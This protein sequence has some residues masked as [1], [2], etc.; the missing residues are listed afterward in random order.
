MYLDWIE[1]R[2]FY[3]KKI[4]RMILLISFVVLLSTFDNKIVQA[5][6]AGKEVRGVWVATVENLDWP[7]KPGLSI[8]NQKNEMINNLD[9]IKNMNLNTVYFQ[10]RSYGDAMYNSKL[11]PWSKFLTGTLGKNPGYDPLKFAVEEAHKRNLEF[12]AWFNPFRIGKG[13]NFNLSEY[14]ANLPDNDSLKNNPQW[15]V[16]YKGYYCINPGIPE[17]RA[18]VVNVIMEV[19]KNYNI[20]GVHLDDYFYPYGMNE[21]EVVFD[22][23]SQYQKYGDGLA[24]DD[25][26]RNNVNEFIRTLN[27]NIK[28]K[29]PY[30]KFGVSPFGI[31][32]NGVNNGGSETA[33]LSSYDR[34][35]VDTL[36]WVNQG[37]VDYIV[38]QIYWNIGFNVAPYEKLVKWW[39]D[40]VKNKNV[41]L[42]IGQAAYRIENWNNPNE[43]IN[44]INLNRSYSNVNGSAFFRLGSLKENKLGSSDLIKNSVFMTPSQS[45]SNKLSVSY[46]SHIQNIGWLGDRLNSN[47]SGTTGKSLRL[48]ALKINLQNQPS[49]LKIKYRA[50]IEKNGWQNWVSGGKVAGTVGKSLKL[51]AFQVQLEGNTANKYTVEYQTYVQ[52]IGWLPWVKNGQTSRYEGKGK[53]V[54]AIRIRIYENPLPIISYQSHVQDIG[55]MKA[56]NNE[57]FSGTIGLGKRLEAMKIS[58]ENSK[59]DL[60]VKYRA[61][62]QNLGWQPWVSGGQTIGTVGKGYRTEGFQIQ[63]EGKDSSKYKLL[64]QVH[65]QDI[66]WMPW[67]SGGEVSGAIGKGKRVEAIRIKIVSN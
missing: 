37:W 36:K 55:W 22:D 39:S 34:I 11:V 28:N 50:Y 24:K 4:F 60:N 64:Y 12:Q 44:Q 29:K 19:V 6:S 66:G 17:A 52:D 16:N 14:L 31:W 35:Y 48:E 54:E 20:D 56:V 42:I 10:V 46:S 25:W 41:D 59:E 49:D 5:A 40:N 3:M 23:N 62:V 67:V 15:I 2:S 27:L 51:E 58:I 38:P 65:V 7:S 47:I 26:R 30:V 57:E 1:D 43:I 33:G 13:D 8:I 45:S 53:R 21:S 9:F 18:Y 32:K 61:Y 63:L